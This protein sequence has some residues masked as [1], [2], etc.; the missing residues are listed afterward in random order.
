MGLPGPVHDASSWSF[1]LD[2]TVCARIPTLVVTGGWHP[3]YEDIAEALERA[4]ALR[5][6][7]PGTEHRPQDDPR[8]NALVNEFWRNLT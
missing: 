2:P 1:D 3:I 6:C 5:A 8:A 4:G 7:I